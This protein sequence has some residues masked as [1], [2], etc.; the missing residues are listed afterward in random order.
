LP[1]PAVLPLFVRPFQVTVCST[2]GSRSCWTMVRTT[3]SV[4]FLA[5]RMRTSVTSPPKL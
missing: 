3:R 4:L 1:L 2:N 5:T